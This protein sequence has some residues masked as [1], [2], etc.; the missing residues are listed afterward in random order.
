MYI[1]LITCILASFLGLTSMTNENPKIGEIIDD[2][3]GVTIRYNG[4]WTN[5]A[6]RNVTPDGYN[7]GLKWQ[8]VEFVKR[9]YYEYY[10]HK[11]PDSYGHAKDFFDRRL[12]DIGFNRSRGMMQYRNIRNTR[13]QINDILVYDAGHQNPYGHVAIISDV[14]S[15]YLEMIQQN[16]GKN[17]RQTL[18][19]IE[20]Q[21]IYTIA[22]FD[23]LGW[24]RLP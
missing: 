14:G 23:I 13:P 18:Q 4:S 11:M 17:S 7:L 21:G 10:G 1:I 5:V 8:C 12:D 16:V 9:Y 15:D 3:N 20:Y 22:D 24:L 19:L 2:L 6:G